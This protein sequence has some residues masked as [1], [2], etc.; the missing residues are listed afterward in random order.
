MRSIV[1]PRDG[2]EPGEQR[3]RQAVLLGDHE[4]KIIF[5]SANTRRWLREFFGR[6]KRA[7][8]P[9]K[10]CQWLAANKRGRTA[11]AFLVRRRDAELLVMDLRRQ[12]EKEVVM[13]I[14]ARRRRGGEAL[15]RTIGPLTAREAEVVYWLGQGKSDADIAMILVIS[16]ATV[17]KHL[18]H[19]YPKLGVENRTAAASFARPS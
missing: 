7:R 18:E 9:A 1:P 13:L 8:L 12:C 5:A 17:G 3:R 16:P 4:G 19:I 6:P 2:P 15:S 14:L 11:P 10:L